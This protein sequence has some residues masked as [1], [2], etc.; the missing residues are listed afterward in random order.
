MARQFICSQCGTTTAGKLI[1]KGN[2]LL[3][4]LLWCMFIVPG[5]IYSMWRHLTRHKGC[6]ACGS[7]A[8]VPLASPRGARLQ[9][10]YQGE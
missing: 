9:R 4:A 2:I 3:E 6:T 8:L 5:L 10:D 1:T 7:A